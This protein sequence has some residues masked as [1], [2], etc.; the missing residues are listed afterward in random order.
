MCECKLQPVSTQNLKY[1]QADIYL[2]YGHTQP[3]LYW[4]HICSC[5]NYAK[6]SGDLYYEYKGEDM[7]FENQA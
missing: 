6:H 2:F 1:R 7:S 5:E 3:S 4:L